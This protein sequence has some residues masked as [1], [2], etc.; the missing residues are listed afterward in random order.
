MYEEIAPRRKGAFRSVF[1]TVL[2]GFVA[3]SLPN[4]LSA[5]ETFFRWPLQIEIHQ[6]CRGGD[7]S[8][9]AYLISNDSVI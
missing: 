9:A 1:L 2:V 6:L 4:W 5:Y 3:L 7:T 8:V